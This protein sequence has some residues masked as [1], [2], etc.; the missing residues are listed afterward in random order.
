MGRP[1]PETGGGTPQNQGL[2]EFKVLPEQK[3]VGPHVQKPEEPKQ[4]QNNAEIEVYKQLRGKR[5]GSTV[6]EN[7]IRVPRPLPQNP[8]EHRGETEPFQPNPADQQARERLGKPP[9]KRRGRPEKPL[10]R[11]DT[12]E[13]PLGSLIRKYRAEKGMPMKELAAQVGYHHHS[14]SRI[15]T[16]A[17]NPSSVKLGKTAESL[18]VPFEELLQAPVHPRVPV[19]FW[20]SPHFGGIGPTPMRPAVFGGHA[21]PSRQ[22]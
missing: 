20:K 6:F 14:L 3:G 7:P 16:N 11:T 8:G 21:R 17:K 15:E 12:G 19:P 4:Q 22:H 1:T 5:W 10:E 13:L 2:S 9:P 18:E